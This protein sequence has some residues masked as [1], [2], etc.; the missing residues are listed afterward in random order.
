MD[1]ACGCLGDVHKYERSGRIRRIVA[2]DRDGGALQ[3]AKRRSKQYMGNLDIDIRCPMDCRDF[4][5]VSDDQRE[6]RFDI[7]VC[8]FAVRY[9]TATP[10]AT[11]GLMYFVRQHI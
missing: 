8:N 7:V 1:L 6:E 4:E 3:E 2:V 5:S 10:E 11:A 9:F